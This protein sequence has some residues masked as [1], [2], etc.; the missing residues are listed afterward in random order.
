MQLTAFTS[1]RAQRL[2]LRLRLRPRIERAQVGIRN[3]FRRNRHYALETT[4]DSKGRTFIEGD[5]ASRAVHLVR[6]QAGSPT[7]ATITDRGYVSRRQTNLSRRLKAA[8]ED[9]IR[10]QCQGNGA[11]EFVVRMNKCERKRPRHPRPAP[12][13]PTTGNDALTLRRCGYAACAAYVRTPPG[14]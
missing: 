2:R 10:C 8:V 12:L 4:C 14:R 9:V 5:R 11:H 7:T 1:L 3:R 13:A 6:R